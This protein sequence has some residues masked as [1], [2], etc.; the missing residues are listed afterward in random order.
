MGSLH[1]VLDR[2]PD[3][4]VAGDILCSINDWHW[5]RLVTVE[6]SQRRHRPRFIGLI[7]LQDL[8]TELICEFARDFDWNQIIIIDVKFA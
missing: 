1:V 6:V 4:D 5:H 8:T 2:N 7:R 3:F